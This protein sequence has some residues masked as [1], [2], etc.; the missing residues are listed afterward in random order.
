MSDEEAELGV[1][2]RPGKEKKNGIISQDGN[3]A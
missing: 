2:T 1:G 3:G